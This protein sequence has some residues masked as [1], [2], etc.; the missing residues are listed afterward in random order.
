MEPAT[1]DNVDLLVRWSLDAVA[2]GP[3]KRVPALSPAQMRERI[4]TSVDRQYFMIRQRDTG[5]PLGRFYWRAW[6]FGP[7]ADRVDYELNPMIAD[8][9][10]RG[11]GFG[12]DAQR[13]A[14]MHLLAQPETA[15]VFALTHLDNAA[16]RKALENAG[17]AAAGAL[18]NDRYP[19]PEP[20][21]PCVLYAVA[22]AAR[23]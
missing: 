20:G 18:P 13:A 9:A 21:I 2:N 16:E 22:A 6:R 15:S 14:V 4:L 10:N 12:S 8:P 11:R 7:T 23:A 3:Y 17:L 5:Q 1:R 19:V